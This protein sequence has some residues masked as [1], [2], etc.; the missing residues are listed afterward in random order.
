MQSIQGVMKDEVVVT[1]V[2]KF[3]CIYV[4]NSVYLMTRLCSLVVLDCTAVK[5]M[6]RLVS[7]QFKVWLNSM[8][9]KLGFGYPKSCCINGERGREYH[10]HQ[11][12]DKH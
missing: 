11:R 6:R 10:K 2:R 4:T 3:R 5:R 1:R 9:A 8:L 7:A 12:D